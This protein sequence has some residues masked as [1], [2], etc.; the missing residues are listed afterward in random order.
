VTAAPDEGSAVVEFLGVALVLL[1]PIVYLVLTLGRLQAAAFA[2]DGAAREAVRVVV[3]AAADPDIDPGTLARA[4]ARVALADQGVEAADP[5]ALTCD[6]ACDTPGAD[7][8]V[9]VEVA[10]DLPLVPS[11]V[12]DRV[13]LAV[14]VSAGA[15]GRVETFL[16]V[17]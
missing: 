15:R 16:D 6:P 1:V 8:V 10:V 3:A 4:A 14:P 11:F 7:V 9:R 17:G 13:P 5:V 2:V 12:R